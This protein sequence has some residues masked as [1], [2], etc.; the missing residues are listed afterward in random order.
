MGSFALAHTVLFRN[1]SSSE[2]ER[3]LDVRVRALVAT[4][5][6]N[7]LTCLSK[8]RVPNLGEDRHGRCICRTRPQRT[9]LRG[10]VGFPG[11]TR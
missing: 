10:D 6:L 2:T 9:V 11:E 1:R 3:H 7:S 4:T 8:M 5:G